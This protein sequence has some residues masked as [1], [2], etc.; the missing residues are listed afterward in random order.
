MRYTGASPEQLRIAMLV[1]T[2]MTADTRV[3]REA[4][5]LGLAGHDVT[6]LALHRKD[7]PTR[8]DRDGFRIDRAIEAASAGS[9][10]NPFRKLAELRRRNA[11]TASLAAQLDPDIIHCHDTDTLPAGG[12][13][14]SATGAALIYDAH[15]L[16]L[17]MVQAHGRASVALA[18][19]T[20]VERRW[21]PRC[22]LRIAANQARAELLAERYGHDFEVVLNVP[23]LEPLAPKG[24]L[25]QELGLPDDVPLVLYQGGLIPGRSLVRLVAATASVDRLH[26]VIQGAGPQLD[27]MRA[28]ALKADASDR[29]HFTG[30]V[31]PGELHSYACGADIGVVIYENTS[32]N[33]FYAAPN[34][35]WAYMMAGLP[36]VA[37]DFPGLHDVVVGEEIGKVFDPADQG[38]I[39]RAIA[40]VL[41]S[42]EQRLEMGRR[43]RQLAEERY[44]W[45]VESKR[46]LSMYEQLERERGRQR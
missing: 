19:W 28:A 17:D 31:S 38:S 29:V 20:R 7:L 13:A 27:A 18:Y 40:S 39:A 43:A 25:R 24:R 45:Q 34:K 1:H 32:L 16:F 44:N 33:N 41:G 14:A 6:V 36:V 11:R 9:R 4:S 46:F 42:D 21:I 3:M 22:D 30:Q 8:E 37:S 10:R 2:D 26:L 15:E 35:L 12:R 5:A 23:E